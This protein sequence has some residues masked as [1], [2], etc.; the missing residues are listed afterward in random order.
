MNLPAGVFEYNNFIDEEDRKVLLEYVNFYDKWLDKSQID[1]WADKRME[2]VD[3]IAKKILLK[4]ENKL[5]NLLKE[6]NLF[7][8][9][10]T[11]H[12]M[13]SGVGMDEHTDNEYVKENIYGFVLYLNDNFN[14]GELVYTEHNYVY[15]PKAGTLM[16]HPCSMKH[17]VNNVL[18]WPTRYTILAFARKE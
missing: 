10:P 4:I 12:R 7:P 8:T 5:I 6:K 14:G 16:M 1:Y 9:N 3:E 13:Y 11:I 15:K 17:M 2:F 18:E